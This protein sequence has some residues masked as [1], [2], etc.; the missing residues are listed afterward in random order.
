MDEHPA[1]SDRQVLEALVFDPDLETLETLS[2]EFNI[3]E[4]VGAVRQELRHSDFLGFLLDPHQNHGL[5]QSFLK[6]FLQ[7]ALLAADKPPISAIDLDLMDLDGAFVLREWRNIDILID[8]SES[9]N[10]VVL[11]ENKIGS[12]EHSG[13]LGRYL[14]DIRGQFPAAILLPIFLT[15]DGDEPSADDY[16]PVSYETVAEVL[17]NLLSAQRSTMGPDVST[18]ASHYVK[19]L[20]RHIVSDSE[21]A[22]LCRKIYRRHQRALDLLF[23]YRPDLQAEIADYLVDLVQRTK[24]VLLSRATKKYIEFLPSEWNSIPSL[25][26]AH[27]KS[28]HLLYF[29]FI[30]YAQ[31][32][33]WLYI[34]PG[35]AVVRDALFAFKE[36]N[37][38]LFKGARSTQAPKYTCLYT[39][40]VLSAAELYGATLEDVIPKI[41]QVWQRFLAKD[42]P[43]IRDAILAADLP[44]PLSDG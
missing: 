41:E 26:T 18:L 6:R 1:T 42:L 8:A 3:F 38:P 5:G 19:M 27:T 9:N 30:N 10:L 43:A 7:G 36:N 28:G 39:M 23:E 25:L 24:G 17:D 37:K 29:S 13:Q 44:T 4:A 12:G 20:R 34:G 21:I 16:L 15:P 32:R 31:L 40:P 2:A 35:P 22:N 33:L 11:I 14:R